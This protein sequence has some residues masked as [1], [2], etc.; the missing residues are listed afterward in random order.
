MDLYF[1]KS[2][3]L[4]SI[5]IYT[6]VIGLMIR[7]IFLRTFFAQ[8][9]RFF[10]LKNIKESYNTRAIKVTEKQAIMSA[11]MIA[12]ITMIIIMYAVRH[13]AGLNNLNIVVPG[14]LIGLGISQQMEGTALETITDHMRDCLGTWNT[15]L[16][17]F[18]K[19]KRGK[20][21]KE[22]IEET[23]MLW[24]HPQIRPISGFEESLRKIEGKLSEERIM[25]HINKDREE[26]NYYVQVEDNNASKFQFAD[27]ALAHM[28]NIRDTHDNLFD[29]QQR[30]GTWTYAIY[31]G[32]GTIIWLIQPF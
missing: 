3:V 19:R 4:M 7:D 10:R 25:K 23:E 20:H 26:L 6:F 14:I 24:A 27:H 28:R 8:I 13:Y 9:L 18:A 21:W 32:I 5:R 17:V 12:L 15:V 30:I 31:L 29:I 11:R 2:P 1:N 16:Y 22:I